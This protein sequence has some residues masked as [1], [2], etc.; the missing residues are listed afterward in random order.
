M[1]VLLQYNGNG[2]LNLLLDI[3]SKWEQALEN[4]YM[5]DLSEDEH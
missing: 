2:K 1:Y 5:E 3:S 4:S